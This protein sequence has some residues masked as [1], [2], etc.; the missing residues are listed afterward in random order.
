LLSTT[1]PARESRNS[2]RS[3]GVH[4]IY[5][6]PCDLVRNEELDFDIVTNMET[7][8]DLVTSRRSIRFP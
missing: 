7:H 3:S 4:R 6:N 2:Q 5:D 1:A 8:R